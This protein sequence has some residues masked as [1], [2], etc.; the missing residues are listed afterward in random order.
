[1]GGSILAQVHRQIG[2]ECPDIDAGSIKNLYQAIIQLKREGKI[3]AYH[4]KSAGGLMTTL[5]EIAFASHAGLNIDLSSI[6]AN[7]KEVNLHKALFNQEAGIVIQIS[8][9]DRIKI[10][11]ML[12]EYNIGSHI[13]ARP[14]FVDDPNICVHVAGEVVFKEKTAELHK[15]WSTVSDKIRMQRENPETVQ[16][17]S[18]VVHDY[19]RKAIE[20]K[21]TFDVSQ[22][23]A[24]K[25]IADYHTQGKLKPKVAIL[26]APGTNGD[27]E[28]ANKFIMA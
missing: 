11:E 28:M 23:P 6:C 20:Y 10:R 4:D 17:E 2:D 24:H 9:E 26:R 19:T 5:S 8:S 18:E 3:L 12:C 15:V 22:H 27:Q 1:M 21:R 16:S 13:I 14:Q 7:T 25:I